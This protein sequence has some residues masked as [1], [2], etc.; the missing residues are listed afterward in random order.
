MA[1]DATKFLMGATG[2]SEKVVS[3]HK[4]AIEAGIAV[5]LKSDNTLSIASA[6]GN[7]LGISLGK[8]LSNAGHTAIARKGLLIPI[9]L[10]AAFNP[11]VGAAVSISDTTGLAIAAGGGATVVNA[12]YKSERMEDGGVGEDGVAKDIALIDFPGGL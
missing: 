5:R 10:T 9:Q 8:D 11:T 12:V 6:D 1:H 4:G 2:S 3:N 7:L